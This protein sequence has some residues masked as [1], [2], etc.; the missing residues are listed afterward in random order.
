MYQV[1]VNA[2]LK[3]VEL[4]RRIRTKADLAPTASVNPRIVY[5]GEEMGQGLMLGEV[6]VKE[7]TKGIEF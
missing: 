2:E 7:G 6:R 3:V 4:I 5:N 1:Q